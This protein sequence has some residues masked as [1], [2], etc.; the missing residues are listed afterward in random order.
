MGL[1]KGEK[2]SKMGLGRTI[3]SMAEP[4]CP[5]CGAQGLGKIALKETQ[6]PAKDDKVCLTVVFCGDCGHIYGVFATASMTE[7]VYLP[8]MP[9]PQ[10]PSGPKP[11]VPPELRRG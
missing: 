2:C 6:R 7:E 4:K 3:I 11:S 10:M 8:T 1:Q 5:S 9:T